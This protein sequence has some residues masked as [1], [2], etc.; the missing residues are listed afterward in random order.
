M[1]FKNK[2]NLNSL[3]VNNKDSIE[4]LI[5]KN[6]KLINMVKRLEKENKKLKSEYSTLHSA[7][8]NTQEKYK[9]AIKDIPLQDI[10]DHLESNL[11]LIK[12]RKMC[13]DCK[14]KTLK[15]IGVGGFHIVVC[16]NCKYRDRI[17]ERSIG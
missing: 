16:G 9:E 12:M 14:E 3:R 5:E 4:I 1:S 8:D 10:M 7:W 17:N 11:S 13:P 15:K 6:E 2:K